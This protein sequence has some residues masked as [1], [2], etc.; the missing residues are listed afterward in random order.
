MSSERSDPSSFQA[1]RYHFLHC[2]LESLTRGAM[3]A[4]KINT[5]IA[6]DFSPIHTEHSV[7]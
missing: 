5:E 3:Q 6:L 1:S 2:H 7:L 4:V